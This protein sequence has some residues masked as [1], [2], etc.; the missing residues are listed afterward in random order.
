M[1]ENEIK[2]GE[3]VNNSWSNLI[4]RFGELVDTYSPTMSDDTI[5]GAFYGAGGASLA[6]MPSIQN[7]RVK[8]ISPLPVDY[9]KEQIGDFLRNPLEN[10]KPLGQVA[11]TLKYT[12]Y[13]WFK[14][15]KTYSDIPT[16][17]HYI[18][19]LYIT[20]EKT[21]ESETFKREERLLDKVV[22]RLQPE[23]VCH[24]IC[25]QALLNGKVFYYPR[26]DLDREHNNCQSFFMQ[27]LP[28]EYCKIIGFNNVSGYT[29]SF[30]LM[31]F[32]QPGTTPAQFGDIFDPF[33]D[34]FNKSFDE[35][36]TIPTRKRKGLHYYSVENKKRV[37]NPDK[38][39][40]NAI[41][42]PRVFYQNGT[43]MYYVSLPIDKVFTFEID[44]TTAAV[45]SPFG[46]LML[47][48]AQQA[49]YESAQ[50]ALLVS[51]LIKIFTGE[52]P[53]FNDSRQKEDD[54]Y[55]LSAGGRLLF[56]TLFNNLMAA[57]NT[58]GTAFFMAPVQ[59]I[60]SHDFPESS[61][62]NNISTTFNRYGLEKAGLSGILPATNDPKAGVAELSAKLESRFVAC[63]YNDFK[64]MMNYLISTFN[65]T[66]EWAF[67][68]F[69]T[70]YNEEAIRQKAE[71]ALAN[72][73]T[74]AH[75]I[76][77]ALD[78]QSFL[79][80]RSMC[81][82]VN[83]SGFLDLLIPPITSY[84]MKQEMSGLPPRAD[85]GR[86]SKDETETADGV[87]E[88]KDDDKSVDYRS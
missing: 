79:D 30:N 61:N 66:H 8:A 27:Q 73:D 41:G 18:K 21:V 57:T 2:G 5:R 54:G 46:G 62:A 82:S 12:S 29:V 1:S 77:A 39:R 56:E 58:G 36:D 31:Y 19:P 4:Q 52:I 24:K 65:L 9:S 72:G 53:Y 22:K 38:V 6:N 81:L 42:N 84:T 87:G 26:I 20:D 3:K 17:R 63:I 70:I 71:K 10:E 74:S 50:L 33:L 51:P 64:R 69:G 49:D 32:M 78:G 40:K 68:M 86:P 14:I 55:R 85:A 88:T 13:P 16:Y 83:K 37:F 47:T 7:R 48:L 25:G 28:Q 80:K 23:K 45:V 75:Y 35:Y 67:E 15:I 44:D 76:L 34:D 11:E 59:N 60:R 43:W